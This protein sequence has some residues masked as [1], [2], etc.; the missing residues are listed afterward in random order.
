[1]TIKLAIFLDFDET[2][3]RLNVTDTVLE[4]FA[5]PLW[6]EFQQDWL[7]GNLSAREVLERQM[8]LITVQPKDLD[9]L[10]DSIEV[11]PFFAE[12]AR[13]AS[14]DDYSL[15]ILSDGFDYWIERI[16]G[17]ALS[18][19]DGAVSE[20][21]IFACSLRMNGTQV[22]ISFPHFPRGCPHGCAT[23]KPAL[24]HRL[25]A[26]A[27]R[28][29]VVGDGISD[30]LIA[31]SADLVLAKGRL[32]QFCQREGIKSYPFDDFRDVSCMIDSATRKIK[33]ENDD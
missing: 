3:T 33:E 13:I 1:M 5:N 30:L 31:R 14:Q 24:F 32:R 22:A 8:P 26:S 11:D 4:R 21:P 18:H 28:T 12:F 6:R 19:L 9:A 16:L 2:I 15:Y 27:E 10:I 20:I 17:R 29:I 23:C 25:K 7:A